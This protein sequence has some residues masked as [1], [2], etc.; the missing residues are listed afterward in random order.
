[1]SDTGGGH[2]ASAEAIRDAVLEK[3]DAE[4][5][6]VDLFKHY[7]PYPFNK[8]PEWYPQ[9]VS[10]KGRTSYG[11]TYRLSNTHNRAR[12][13]SRLMYLTMDNRLRQM[14]REHPAD[15]YVSVHSIL[16]RLTGHALSAQASR[17]SFMVVVTDLVSTHMLWYDKRADRTLVPTTPAYQRALRAG[18]TPAQLRD[19]GLPVNPRFMRSLPEKHAARETLGWDQA[20]PT[21]LIVGGG[22]GM[23]PLYETA[24]AIDARRLPCQ[25]AII[26][27]KNQALKAQLEARTWNQPTHVFGFVKD[28][29]RLMAASDILVTKAGPSTICESA[30]AGLPMIIYDYIPGQE[31]G[32]VTYVIDNHAGIYAPTGEAVSAAVSAWLANDHRLLQQFAAGA[33]AIARP[34]A[35]FDIAEE[36]WAQANRPRIINP[37]PGLLRPSNLRERLRSRDLLDLL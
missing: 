1:M 5:E 28:M 16:T 24:R 14:L 11:M 22:E 8:M 31:D 33:R 19:T 4:F 35:V 27:G 30:I 29:P 18:L 20:L 9:M 36:V 2:R 3:H 13:Y 21:I 34:R 26:A 7:S 15:V 23:G 17:P 10:P 12:A 25:I 37:K 32:N 6:L